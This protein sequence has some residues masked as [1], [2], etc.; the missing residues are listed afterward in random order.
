MAATPT[1]SQRLQFR[2]SV[3]TTEPSQQ[4]ST[5][6][7]ILRAPRS[8]VVT[9]FGYGIK[10]NVE[11]GH[12]TLEDG[13]GTD[14][15]RWRFPRV[16]HGLRRLVVIGN[17]GF[18]SLAALRWLADQDAAFVMLERDG[19]VLATTGPVCPSDARLRR[20][21]ARVDLSPA[22]V[23]ISCGLISHKL[24]RQE[25]IAREKLHDAS[26]ANLIAQIER[27][28]GTAR[29]VR[30]VQLIES[31][32]SS[33]YWSAWGNL[34]IDF[35]QRD[36]KKVPAHWRTFGSRTAPVSHGARNAANPANCMLNYL[37]S[38]LEAETR[39]T[40]AALG[41]DPGL[42]LLHVDSP[43][44]DSL[45]CDL[46]EPIRPSVDAVLIDWIRQSPL[47]REWFFEQPDGTCRLMPVLAAR[48][49]ETALKWRT[50]VAPFAEWFAQAVC[51]TS[52]DSTLRGPRTR[53]TRRHWREAM[54]RDSAPT[55]TRAPEPQSVCRTCGAAVSQRRGLCKACSV[56]VS[57]NALVKGA[58]AGRV[59][60]RTPEA[61]AR[62]RK[63]SQRQNEALQA[64]NPAD[65][66]SWLTNE[67]YITNI[68][69]RL[70][71]LTRPQIAEAL[72]VS[73]VYAGEI[74]NGKCVPHPRHWLR[75]AGL[76]GISADG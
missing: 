31:Q 30:D 34:A 67:Y 41:L 1:V 75:L 3:E 55:E 27:Q 5:E 20:A 56:V 63:S 53:L 7:P 9:L 51:S 58:R 47:K 22:A 23:P 25:S 59:A 46:M 71:K 36:L 15:H 40:I 42:G 72:G 64:W 13:I 24:A 33:V 48:L 38:L 65:H 2:K 14:R 43:T 17:D 12:L 66:P 16:G 62:R 74:R 60:A 26:A 57:T 70:A 28:L 19:S 73:V 6:S 21:Q 8:G 29:S 4:P 39:L 61:L 49:A 32:G 68:Q 45:A 10:I 35:P 54:R 50:E 37:Y 76:V 69:P 18:V 44:R 52:T 11:R